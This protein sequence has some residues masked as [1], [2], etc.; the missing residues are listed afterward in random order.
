MINLQTFC[1]FFVIQTAVLVWFIIF[2]EFCDIWQLSRNFK[3]WFLFVWIVYIWNW[4]L[5]YRM[6]CW[7]IENDFC[8]FAAKFR[9]GDLAL[10]FVLETFISFFPFLVK[11]QRLICDLWMKIKITEYF[12][13]FKTRANAPTSKLWKCIWQY[14]FAIIDHFTL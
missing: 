10:E 6:Q 9:G 4:S 13:A 8:L 2:K 1:F 14:P 7:L 3:F 12:W 5:F 11:V